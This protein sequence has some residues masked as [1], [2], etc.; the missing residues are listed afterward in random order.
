MIKNLGNEVDLKGLYK[1]LFREETE[2]ILKAEEY[3]EYRA[4]LSK[5]ERK[6]IKKNI[7]KIAECAANYFLERYGP[8]K[9][10]NSKWRKKIEESLKTVILSFKSSHI[11]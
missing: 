4:L 3:T 10:N 1:I 9:D 8:V 11:F 2:A 7:E 6:E 5:K